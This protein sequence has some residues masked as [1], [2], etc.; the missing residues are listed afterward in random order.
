MISCIVSASKYNCQSCGICGHITSLNVLVGWFEARRL[1]LTFRIF[2]F[3]QEV[4][5][6]LLL[7]N[8]R[9]K[10]SEPILSIL[11]ELNQTHSFKVS[12]NVSILSKLPF[13]GPLSLSLCLSVSLS[14]CLSVCL[15]L[16]LS[17]D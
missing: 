17:R 16:S 5:V 7:Q 3:N 2:A 11:S 9:F 6:R 4:L 13:L 1:G 10:S 12:E 8:C 14:V 15:S